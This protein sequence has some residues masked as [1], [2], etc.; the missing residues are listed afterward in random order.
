MI[1]EKAKGKKEKALIEYSN[2]KEQ[3]SL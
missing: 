1:I 2:A 3:K